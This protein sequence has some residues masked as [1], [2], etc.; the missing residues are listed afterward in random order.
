MPY[1]GVSPFNGV[2]RK[3]TYTATASQTSFSGAG[4]EGITLSYKDSTFVDVFQNGVK[5]GEADYTSTSGTAIVLAQGASLNDI[6]EVVVYDVFSVADTVSKADGGTFDGNVTMGG[7][8]AVTGETTLA[9]HLNMGDSDKIKLGASGDLE[10]YHDGSNSF[11]DD[12]GTGSLFLRGESQVI[13]GNMTGEQA[14]VFNDDGAVTLNHDNTKKFETTSS[15]VTVTG[16]ITSEGGD[17]LFRNSSGSSIVSI[18][19]GTSNSSIL[20]M[21]DTDDFDIGQIL[22]HHGVNQMVFHVNDTDFLSINSTGHL[23]LGTTSERNSGDLSIDFSGSSEAGIGIN[24][25]TSSNGSVFAGFLTGGTFRGS[26]TNNNNGAVAYNTTSDYR[27]KENVSYDFDATARLKQ[28]KPARFNWIADD[29][30]TLQDGFLA[31]E[32][33]SIVPEAI[34]GTKDGTKTTANVVLDENENI[35]ATGLTEDEWKAGK[36]IPKD[37]N[38]KDL[39]PMFASN[40]T[41]KASI[42]QKHYQEIDQAKLVP[43]LV[44]TI[45]ELEARIAVLESK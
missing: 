11:V 20:K 28:L 3:H 12:T 42:T 39:T 40:T 41:W 25:T 2:R 7:T 23:F 45:Q 24:D 32:V 37:S 10:V 8:L 15:G 5:L 16:S 6:V 31:H 36:E 13:I 14:A 9:T 17:N 4:A 33:S 19:A 43:L 21:G 29:T 44:K 1:I 34:T 27:L 38:G 22:Y 30:N 35:I 26:I 18:I